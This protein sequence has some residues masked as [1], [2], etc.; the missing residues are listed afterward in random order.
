VT[1]EER[2]ARAIQY[3]A[4][5]EDGV[6]YEALDAVE[7]QFINEWKAAATT[8]ERENCH[9]VIRVIGLMRSHI[10]SIA[11]GEPD[12]GISAIRRIK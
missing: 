12:G 6:I 2:R 4:A 9:R 10:A 5:L 8:D 7:S 3:N 11:K 1:P